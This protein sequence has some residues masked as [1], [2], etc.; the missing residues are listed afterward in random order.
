MDY[1]E[2]SSDL[3]L[4][5]TIVF[6]SV[7]E[8]D[9]TLRR[10]GVKQE[11]RQLG[12]GKFRSDFAVRCEQQAEFYSDRFNKALCV[13]LEAP[14]DVIYLL[15]PRCINGGFRVCGNDVS[16]NTMLAM[17]A[18]AG[19][20]AVVSDLSGSDTISMSQARFKALGE[21]A[22]PAFSMLESLCSIERNSP[23]C[24]EIQ[25]MIVNLTGNAKYIFN[26]EELDNFLVQTITWIS[27]SVNGRP[28]EKPFNNNVRIAVARKI[29]EYIE[30]NYRVAVSLEH[31]C[32]YAGVGVRTAQRCFIEYFSLTISGYLQMVRLDST[33]R[34]LFASKPQ[35]AS[36]SSVALSNGFTH[37]GRFSVQFS[38]RFG[39]PPR[40]VLIKKNG[41]KT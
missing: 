19:M 17:P 10:L 32:Q 39:M 21:I 11:I 37:L 3:S 24:P 6:N 9:E 2:F 8:Y 40:Q 38:Q 27:H 14:E 16:T 20:D 22:D 23:A 41:C 30:E 5:N 13:H 18:G 35:D 33:R 7:E 28:P 26:Q 31:I 15:F 25:K 36:V 12:N 4:Q 34:E 29:Q 1:L